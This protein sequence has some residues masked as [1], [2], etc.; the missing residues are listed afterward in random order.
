M[1]TDVDEHFRGLGW[2]LALW[3]GVS[4]MFGVVSGGHLCPL[5]LVA[6]PLAAVGTWVASRTRGNGRLERL[7][8]SRSVG[9]SRGACSARRVDVEDA[10]TKVRGYPRF[11]N[12]RIS[13]SLKR[14]WL[15]AG[16]PTLAVAAL[17][18]AG[19]VLTRPGRVF[20]TV[21]NSVPP[22][23]VRLGEARVT[24]VLQDG[25]ALVVVDDL[26]RPTLD[27]LLQS[28]GLTAGEDFK[29]TFEPAPSGQ[30]GLAIATDFLDDIPAGT[31][32][33]VYR[34]EDVL[35]GGQV[36][37]RLRMLVYLPDRGRGY[38]YWLEF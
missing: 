8:L 32:I 20:E 26:D 23:G 29:R 31:P 14:R 28:G 37:E 22:E 15:L 3:I 5:I 4:V 27:R 18:S 2:F 16:L 10:R 38:A 34:A 35:D 19:V 13:A 30:H 11:R 12:S 7:N 33:E 36:L 6:M 9:G 17:L 1:V 21:F 25:A 24:T